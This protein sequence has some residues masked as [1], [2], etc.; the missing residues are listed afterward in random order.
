VLKQ[1]E[2]LGSFWGK[3]KSWSGISR[4]EVKMRDLVRLMAQALVDYP[5]QVEVTEVSGAT[6]TILEL[7][8][9]KEDMGKV[10][11]KSG[12]NAEAM[13]T[14]LGAAGKKLKKRAVLEIIESD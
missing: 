12:R 14:I 6:T 4:A 2:N 9:A 7:R 3:R 11:G 1:Y 13:R 8:V 10:L 5:E